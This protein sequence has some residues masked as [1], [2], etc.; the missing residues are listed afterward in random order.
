MVAADCQEGNTTH[1]AISCGRAT[2]RSAVVNGHSVQRR[3]SGGVSSLISRINRIGS[4]RIAAANIGSIAP[5]V[6]GS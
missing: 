1:R 5:H 6:T 4:S 2:Q 3:A